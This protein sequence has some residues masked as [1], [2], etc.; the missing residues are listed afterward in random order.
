V[1]LLRFLQDHEYR[2]LGSRGTR[3]A[4]VRVITATNVDF[5]RA[6][7][8]GVLRRDLYYRLHIIPVALPPLRERQDDVLRLAE[9][10]LERYAATFNKAVTGLSPEAAQKLTLHAW[11]GNVRELEHV[12]ERAVALCEG[13]LI[14]AP[15]VVLSTRDEA[16]EE[17]FQQAKARAVER[18]E[19]TYLQSMLLAHRG[20]ITRA[21]HAARKNRRAF[22]ELLR[23]HRI[24]AGVFR[25][26]GTGGPPPPQAR[27]FLS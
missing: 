16:L 21:A 23:K 14:H 25:S 17:S 5:E 20:N 6:V 24:D 26:G 8:R 27:T 19:R 15:D 13:P 12:I 10:F 11:P 4:D 18:F 9:C 2:P 7:E 1:K 22:F 3:H